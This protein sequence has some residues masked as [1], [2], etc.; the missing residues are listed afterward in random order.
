[1]G[2]DHRLPPRLYR[3]RVPA[4][5][6]SRS[7]VLLGALAVAVL[8]ALGACS[9]SQ[10]A[11]GQGATSTSASATQAA[12]SASTSPPSASTAA[13]PPASATKQA[14]STSAAPTTRA[15]GTA[16]AAASAPGRLLPPLPIADL[17]SPSHY[18]CAAGLY[19]VSPANQASAACVPYAY[20]P[21]G[22]RAQPDK[23]TACPA[24]SFMTVGPVECTSA[25]GLAAAVPPGK[26]TCSA[27][28]GPCPSATL[29]PSPRASSLPWASVKFP[30]GQCATGYFG[31]ANGIATCVP[32]AYLPGGTAAD[33]NGNT[34]CPAGSALR[35]ARLT[36]TLC[37]SESNPGTVVAPVPPAR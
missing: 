2:S 21:G 25:A 27:P 15:P 24:G 12:P 13:T 16:T 19:L 35:V 8:L 14:L 3:R 28:G 9:A 1:M 36:G 18:S 7:R 23:D 17:P 31:E 22:T 26:D 33:P 6:P 32:Y 20:L 10:H 29:P 5:G 11:A 37:T 4:V 34:A 30:A